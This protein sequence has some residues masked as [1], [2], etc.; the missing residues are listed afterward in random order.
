[1]GGPELAKTLVRER[2]DLR[3]LYMSGYVDSPVV[4]HGL[5]DASQRLLAKPF[6]LDELLRAMRQLLDAPPR[7]RARP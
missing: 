5:L 2:P 3:V 6:S 1:M 4:D 7:A